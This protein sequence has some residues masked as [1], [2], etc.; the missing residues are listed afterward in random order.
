[1]TTTAQLDNGKIVLRGGYSPELVAF[2][3]SLPRARWD[4]T[5]RQWTCDATPGAAWRIVAHEGI[6]EQD[7]ICPLAEQLD[8]CRIEPGQPAIR[9]TEAR[10][11]QV[12]AYRYAMPRAAT[13]LNMDMGTGKTKVAIDLAAN[14]VCKRVLVLCPRSVISVWDDEITKHGAGSPLT[15]PL[16]KGSTAAKTTMA[17]RCI[18]L[19]PEQ[20]R[21]IVV[22]YDTARLK[23]FADWSLDQDWD[24]VI[25]DESHRCK[26]PNGVTAKYVENLGRVATHRLCLTGTPLPHSP[27]DVFSQFRFLDPGLF[28]SSWCRFRERYAVMGG[29]ENHEIVRYQN[30]DEL[31]RLMSLVTFSCTNEV[32]DLPETN[33]HIQRF[34]L[35]KEAQRHYDELESELITQIEDGVVTC[36]NALVKLLRLQQVTSGYLRVDLTTGFDDRQIDTGKAELLAELLEDIGSHEKVV[37]FC[38]FVHDLD[39]VRRVAEVL[40]R[41]CGEISGRYNDYRAW[42]AGHFDDKPCDTLAVQMQ[43]GS[44]GIDL[45]EACYAIYYSLG[46]SLAD[47]KQSRARLHRPGQTRPV[48]YYHLLARGTVDEKVLAA[49]HKKGRLVDSVLQALREGT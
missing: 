23:P 4:A 9:R 29:Y 35:G 15:V 43:A 46:F 32:L 40:G 48:H 33:D 27:L 22:N 17:N 37:V 39:A 47:Y 7:G 3:R 31:E 6:T 28:G 21:V 26:S 36:A 24:L 16:T 2:Y 12:E 30:L 14:W 41:G 13:L 1:M 19:Y 10:R 38:R 34:D 25:L 20:V 5:R 44:L 42:K 18:R 8:P 49:I 45:T 11:H